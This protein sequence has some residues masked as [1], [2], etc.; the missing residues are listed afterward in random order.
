MVIDIIYVGNGNFVSADVFGPWMIKI[1][2]IK[3]T[4]RA[5]LLVEST[6]IVSPKEAMPKE[7][8]IIQ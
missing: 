8:V 1:R 5:K 4:V 2:H 3:G 6:A 7:C